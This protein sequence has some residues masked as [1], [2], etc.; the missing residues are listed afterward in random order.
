[1]LRARADFLRCLTGVAQA[2]G[3][4]RAGAGVL[5]PIEGSYPTKHDSVGYGRLM[6]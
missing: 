4:A 6:R 5:L 1:M 2:Q 3:R